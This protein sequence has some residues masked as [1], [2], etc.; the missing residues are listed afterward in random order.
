M[1]THRFIARLQLGSETTAKRYCCFELSR[2]R[3]HSDRR[4]SSRTT[5]DSSSQGNRPRPGWSY[6]FRCLRCAAQHRFLDTPNKD[7]QY[8]ET[9]RRL[10]GA[11]NVCIADFN[12]D[13]RLHGPRRSF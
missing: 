11:I 5:V 4:R 10:S 1:P 12:L 9:L 2:I 13:G 3:F 6:L 8:K 7:K